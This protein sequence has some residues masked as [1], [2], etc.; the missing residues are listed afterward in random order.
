MSM[1]AEITVWNLGTSRAAH[2]MMCDDA[3]IAMRV[4]DANCGECVKITRRKPY[5]CDSKVDPVAESQRGTISF[6]KFFFLES[7]N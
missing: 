1:M 7:G 3:P 5:R 4:R 2:I 6:V